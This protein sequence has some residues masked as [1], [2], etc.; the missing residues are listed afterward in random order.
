MGQILGAILAKS[1]SEA[2][3]AAKAVHVEY[4][5]KPP[6][7]TIEVNIHCLFSEESNLC[8]YIVT[9]SATLSIS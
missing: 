7:I 5:V 2:Q 3:R 1:I 6:I 8:C 4:D 9:L